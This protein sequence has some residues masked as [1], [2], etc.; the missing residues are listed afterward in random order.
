MLPSDA[1]SKLLEGTFDV[2]E[3]WARDCKKN[4]NEAQAQQG[5]ETQIE[6]DETAAND[7][8]VEAAP[9]QE[10]AQ[11]S[12]AEAFAELIGAFKDAEEQVMRIQGATLKATQAFLQ[13]LKNELE[14]IVVPAQDGPEAEEG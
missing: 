2:V 12:S 6:P 1:I 13:T 9:G 10:E 14:P 5:E 4:L 11:V 8:R 7:D 3:E